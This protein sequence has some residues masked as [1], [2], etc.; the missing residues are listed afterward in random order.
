MTHSYQ[1]R[2]KQYFSINQI[3][4]SLD[5]QNDDGNPNDKFHT[6]S[7]LKII[8]YDQSVDKDNSENLGGN[9]TKSTNS[10]KI[11]YFKPADSP[12]TIG[13]SKCSISLDFSFL[14]KRHCQIVYN[15]I[16]GV[17]EIGDGYNG[18][19]STNGT[20]LLLNSKFEISDT[21]HVKIGSNVI[22]IGLI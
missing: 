18:K 17:W 14:S 11:F 10:N 12:V 7:N 16:E 9:S 1:I 20:W 13:R 19:S 15:K 4:F 22:K 8:I 6:Q 3:A 5:P 2:K 21:T